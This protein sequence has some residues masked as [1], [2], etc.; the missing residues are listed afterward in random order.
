MGGRRAR[1]CTSWMRIL[2]GL[3]AVRAYARAGVCKAQGERRHR[4][5]LVDAVHGLDR[6]VARPHSRPPPPSSHPVLLP[7]PPTHPSTRP[8]VHPTTPQGLLERY[9]GGDPDSDKLRRSAAR[10]VG[11]EMPAGGPPLPASAG[12]AAMAAKYAAPLASRAAEPVGS[13]VGG[14]GG[15][16]RSGLT[17]VDHLKAQLYGADWRE[18][19]APA[20]GT[21][22]YVP[23]AVAQEA[24][25]PPPALT[26]RH[27]RRA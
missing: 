16:A 20:A 10:Y 21:G 22:A 23:P 4:A 24:Q 6:V 11:L 7:Q 12:P 2:L 3:V 1:R 9:R 26:H 19:R 15:A 27:Q 5:G 25:A 8:P 17:G 13:A 14:A 18:E